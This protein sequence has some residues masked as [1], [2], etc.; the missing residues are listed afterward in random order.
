MSLQ[1]TNQILV[2]PPTNF[3][4]NAENFSSNPFQSDI[5]V[6][7]ITEI[8]LSEFQNFVE[9]LINAG[10]KVIVL[11]S[12]EGKHPDAVFPNN[13]FISLPGEIDIMPM[14]AKN[15]RKERQIDAL[16]ARLKE[17]L[18]Q[19]SFE[20]MDYSYF[21]NDHKF[22]EGTGSL[23]LDRINYI[24][25]CCKS[26]R[27]SEEL[28][29]IW[30]RDHGYE[31][32]VFSAKSPEDIPIYHTNVMMNIGANWAVICSQVLDQKY[33]GE[34]ME[35]LGSDREIVDISYSQLLQFAGNIIELS[36]PVCPVIITSESAKNSFTDTQLDALST[37]GKIITSDIS[38]IEKV[39]GGGI[40]CMIAEIF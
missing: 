29:Q 15:R 27:T 20:V 22:L 38:I 33:K 23:V 11:A 26:P 17:I 24:A 36:T 32:I 40:R 25:Y 7:N 6:G 2:V 30:C 12:P 14:M 13:W 16:V 19:K 39:G 21:E 28:A 1:T 10:V 34:I 3:G 37:Y 8:A 31:L 4:F 18:P 35:R 5:K 9:T